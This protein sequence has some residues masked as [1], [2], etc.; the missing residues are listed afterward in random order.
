MTDLATSDVAK[1][2]SAPTQPPN[3]ITNGADDVPMHNVKTEDTSDSR[4]Q[5]SEHTADAV[6]T[7]NDDQDAAG[8]SEAETLIQSPEKLK[9][10]VANAPVLHPSGTAAV[11]KTRENGASAE[12]NNKKTRKRKRDFPDEARPGSPGSSSSPLSSPNP[13]AHAHESD[14]DVSD[15]PRS[16][17]SNRARRSAPRFDAEAADGAPPS[18]IRR[19]RP[20]DIVPPPAKPRTKVSGDS[21]S[22]RRET[23]SATYPRQSDDERSPSPRPTSR[24]QHRR[25][26]STQLISGE[27]ERKKRGRPPNITTKR[28]KSLDRAQSTSSGD[29]SSPPR[30]RPSLEKYDSR[31]HVSPAKPTG[32]RKWRDKNG[33]TFLSRACNNEDLEKVKQCLRERPDDLN[34][35]DNAGN[36]P[37]Q[38]ASLEGF[39]SIVRFLLESEAEVDTRNI[40]KETPLIDAVENG[41]LEVVRLLLE[42]GANPRLANSRGDEP[43]ELVP[44][45]D[46]NYK[47]IRKLIADAKEQDFTKRRK[48]SDNNEGNREGSSR[49][50]SA[51]SPRDSPPLLGPRSPPA[52]TSRRR[53]GRSEST[54]NDLLWQS[55]TQENLK[56][57]AAKGNVQGVATI[58]NVLQK[59]EPAA[60]IAAAK[61]GHEEVLQHLLAMGEVDPDPDPVPDL[62]PGYNTPILAAIGRGNVDVITLLVE[63]TGFNPSKKFKG[64]TY[65]EIAQERKGEKWQQ[66]VEILKDVY[67]KHMSGKTKTK[68]PK[69]IREP[70][71][72]PREKRVR[73]SESPPS[74][75]LRTSTSPTITHKTLPDKSPRSARKDPKKEPPSPLERER[76][77]LET[78]KDDN[79][80][81]VASDQEQTV[82]EK[83]GHKH[84]RSQS[85]LP[86]APSLEADIIQ[87]RR[88]RLVTGKEHRRS[89]SGVGGAHS[90]G[91]GSDIELKRERQGAAHKRNRSSVSPDAKDGAFS[92]NVVKKRRTV[93]ESSPEEARPPPRFKQ[94]MSVDAPEVG[95]TGEDTN[96]SQAAPKVAKSASPEVTTQDA[97]GEPDD[98][99]LG[100]ISAAKED[101][102]PTVEEPQT[103]DPVEQARR[104][105]AQLAEQQAAATKEAEDQRRAEED[106]VA[107]ERAAAEKAEADKAASEKAAVEQL[108]AQRRA[109][110]EAAEAKRKAEEEAAQRLVEESEAKKRAEEE[111]AAARKREEEERLER[112]RRELEDRRL[113]Q[114]EQIRQQHL[115]I[116]RRRRES[117]PAALCH[118][119]LL[120]STG[121]AKAKSHEWL[122]HF[123]PL[124]TVETR[125]LDPHVPA[126]FAHEKWIPNFQAAVL[127][128]SSDM[129]LRHYTLI[130]KRSVTP[131]EQ[132]RLWRVARLMLSF[133][134]ASNSYNTSIKKARQAEQEQRPKFMSMTELAWVKVSHPTVGRKCI[135]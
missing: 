117:L 75:H 124:Y 28:N 89:Q 113:R 43:Y 36:T 40:D 118:A 130:E 87:Q 8:D 10:I 114:E 70:L 72:R 1:D 69:K 122:S 131:E 6:V 9:N 61:A 64:K 123:L 34:E 30:A 38:I 125:H 128:A 97:A 120:L 121:D 110:E 67:D 104:E 21:T 112:Q 25:G 66:E 96:A 65:F 100:E 26:V 101:I 84:R 49:P 76:R 116:E 71:D 88:R 19:R 103:L 90:E 74:S 102:V 20:S 46:E 4:A 80:I 41:H 115:E 86:P 24:G 129:N 7:Q 32:T 77:A 109:A 48:S 15:T 54:R 33:R 3:S 14:S 105:E 59:A 29:D 135:Y 45:D 81:A 18:K 93:L 11:K 47:V 126:A 127:L 56:A 58:L 91:S 83:R 13:Q 82:H 119:S 68:S 79:S 22:E 73:R 111:A 39:V 99:L 27:F 94:T 31:D 62:R 52:H 78:L 55:H 17:R 44:Q 5:L 12:E 35:P 133:D 42:H 51:A 134:Y 98:A 95:P 57:L 63:Q 23:R 108:E 16:A 132:D 107:A 85:D 37:L 60:V 50:P 2:V 92:R 53:T 106:R